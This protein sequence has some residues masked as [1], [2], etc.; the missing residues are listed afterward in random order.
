M[1]ICPLDI[2]FFHPHGWN[3]IRIVENYKKYSMYPSNNNLLSPDQMFS[4][5]AS[6]PWIEG[7]VP[8]DPS[9]IPDQETSNSE[10]SGLIKASSLYQNAYRIFSSDS[11]YG[12]PYLQQL[13]AIPDSVSISDK[14]FWDEFSE[15]FG[16][17][18]KYEEAL[19]DAYNTAMDE[20]RSL[21]TQYYQF[22]NSLPVEQ[23]QQMAEAGINASVTGQGITGSEMST[24][25]LVQPNTSMSEYSNSQISDGISSFVE[26]IGSMANLGSAGVNAANL[27]G[28]LDIAEQE[29]YSKQELHDAMLYELG[30]T[31]SSPY[32]VLKKSPVLS[33]RASKAASDARLG[34]AKSGAAASVLDK[35]ISV[36]IG[37]N[38]NE[39]QSYEIMSGED[40]LNEVSRMQIIEQFSR[41]Y[42]N[43]ITSQNQQLYSGIVS[44]L[45]QEQQIANLNAGIAE[46][47]FNQAFFTSRNGM[48]EGIA[49]TS[50][51]EA[52][53]SIRSSEA[54][55]ASF[56]KWIADYK[57]ATL[58]NW[59]QQLASKPSL[60][61]YFY[62]A[63][64]DF[65]MSD[66]FYHQSP[67]TMGL[68][69]GLE[70]GNGILNFISTLIP[71]KIPSRI[72]RTTS[73]GPR[74]VTETVSETVVQ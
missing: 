42:V 11:R 54:D 37:D 36:P 31:Q 19:R 72:T 38:P 40:I 9:I 2:K 35:S 39:V 67:L 30:I 47:D 60:A 41:G 45:D 3:D 49:Q 28:L 74:G 44:M 6:D 34:R 32:R 59:A 18:S 66:T 15:F 73:S 5:V 56:N 43:Y 26:F 57:Y 63:M 23:V 14:N 29:Q 16:A 1:F 58:D 61:P 20:I 55:I 68:K 64:F 25:G 53:A 13:I 48:S 4:D 21:L 71:T 27:L 10:I 17:T 62:K 50:I 46:G 24:E 22:K 69:Y 52:L 7:T 12:V 33:D 8:V 65:N 51:A 70:I